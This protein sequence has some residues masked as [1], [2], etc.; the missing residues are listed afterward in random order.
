MSVPSTARLRALRR[1]GSAIAAASV[2]RL[3][4]P[5]LRAL[6]ACR[7]NPS[8]AAAV[9]LV[10]S[11]KTAPTPLIARSTIAIGVV[12]NTAPKVPPRT[13]MA[14]VPCVRSWMLP[15]SRSSPPI[16]PA[17]ARAIPE[18][19]ARSGRSP[20]VLAALMAVLWGASV[21]VGFAAAVVAMG[22]K[23]ERLAVAGRR[24]VVVE[25]APP[26]L[27]DALHHCIGGLANAENLSGGQRDHGVRRDIDV[28]DQI[29]VEDHGREVQAGQPD[30]RALPTISAESPN[31][32][33][34]WRGVTDE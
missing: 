19:V 31:N 9:S 6:A 34:E 17:S 21:I 27:H 22:S 2:S 1:N 7:I 14:A 30:H 24:S 15:F 13:I 32:I 11:K 5:C 23:G 8:I 16:I 18:M 25:H 12:T 4:I 10:R 20:P 26:E 28:L 33:N 29:R 3:T